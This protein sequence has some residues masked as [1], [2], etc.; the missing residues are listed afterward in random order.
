MSIVPHFTQVDA[1][2]RLP[3][4]R[5][6]AE[7][8]D[9]TGFCTIPFA[10]AWLTDARPVL[11]MCLDYI[12]VPPHRRRNGFATALICRCVER[13][14]DLVLTEAISPEGEALLASLAREGVIEEG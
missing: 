10:V 14:P 7:L 11:G 12:L 13:W 4:V 2:G 3:G 6:I 9:S 5:W 1:P 8:V